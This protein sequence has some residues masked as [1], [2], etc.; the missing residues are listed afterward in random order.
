RAQQAAAEA[1]QLAL[2]EACQTAREKILAPERARFVEEC[3]QDRSRRS[4]EECERFYADHGNATA[5]RGPLYMDLPECVQAH[6]FRQN[7]R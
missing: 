2:D 4:R 1:E 5:A 3:V 7:N 6:E